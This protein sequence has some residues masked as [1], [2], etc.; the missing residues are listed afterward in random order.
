M[1]L[2]LGGIG[3]AGAQSGTGFD[4]DHRDGTGGL[5]KEMDGDQDPAAAS[6]HYRH[7]G[8]AGPTGIA[9]APTEAGSAGGGRRLEGPADR[10]EVKSSDY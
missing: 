5:G 4:D 3:D 2:V 1:T 10:V 9:P 8:T 7:R 6:P